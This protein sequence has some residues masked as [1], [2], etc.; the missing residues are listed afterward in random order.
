MI[1][2]ILTA[3]L[4]AA[5]SCVAAQAQGTAP[6]DALQGRVI[7]KSEIGLPSGDASISSAQS[8]TIPAS[9]AGPE[10]TVGYC[11]VLGT[12]APVDPN[13]HPIR[14][15]I[16]MP[17]Q[18]NKRAVQ[19]GGGGFNGVLITGLA[20][21]RDAP[22]DLAPPVA[23]GFMTY[24]TDSGHDNSKLK[25]IQEFALNDEMLE[26]FSHAAYKKVRD[27]AIVIARSH[28]GQAPEKLYFFGGSEGGREGLTMAQRYPADFDGIV[29]TV[30]VINWVGLQFAGTR[31]G[32][33][34]MDGGWLSPAKVKLLH[35]AVLAA[36]DGSDGLKDGVI[37]NWESCPRVMN[38]KSLR[39]PD[40]KDTGDTC[41]SDAQ[42]RFIETVHGRFEFP[43]PVANGVTS[44]PGYNYGGEN[45]V[46]GMITWM[47]GPKPPQ[48]P[49]PAAAEQGRIWYYGAG[50]MR[51]FIARDPSAHPRDI[52]PAA[53]K[54]Q[55]LKISAL[56]DSTNP[57]LSAFQRRG[58][59]LIL[60]ENMADP[61][62]SA[63]AGVEY[64]RSVVAKMGQGEVD[65]F[66]RFYV[67]P[68]AN[69][70]GA[71]TLADGSSLPRGVDLLGTLDTWLMTSDAPGD[72]MQLAQDMKPPFA[73]V[74]AR[75]M[76]RYPS[77][78]RYKG[79]GDPKDA[80]SFACAR[81]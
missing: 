58:G 62:Q 11:K 26:N 43:F 71:G 50:A 7:A 61:G 45:Q 39:C 27:V 47:T 64:Y 12:I 55:V 75:P 14:F 4:A 22:L 69:H 24:G 6:C 67:S 41:F 54:D 34:Q 2:T 18:W 17:A 5:L 80:S 13:A 40:G 36:C 9:M 59:K 1:R 46:D 77:W 16:N 29:S 31:A 63:N 25:E 19:Y 53:H 35:E 44:Y 37:S 74:S 57:D 8:A 65:R 42:I 21:L 20:P 49:L 38:A 79:N 48:Y 10:P 72:L 23:R 32:L 28:Y 3:G 81:E 78:P 56:M 30:P 73:T 33:V 68:G 66:V 70:A 51:Y 60:K 15:Q 76:C 52:T